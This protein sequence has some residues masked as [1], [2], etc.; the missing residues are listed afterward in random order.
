MMKKRTAVILAL[1]L[2]VSLL[3]GCGSGGNSQQPAATPPASGGT[4]PATTPAAPGQ[5]TAAG[6]D[7]MVCIASDPETIDPAR[8]SSVDGATILQNA[9][10]GLY[11]WSFDASGRQIVVADCAEAVVD[12]VEMAGGKYQYVV[13]LKPGLKWSDGAELKASDFV[14]AWN[15]AVDPA[16]LADY[17]YIFDVIDGYDPENPNLN[18][19]A[20]DDARTV[21]IVTSAYCVYFNQLLAFP[22]YFPVRRDI[23]EADPDAWATKVNSYISNGAFKMTEWVVGSYIRF[24][25]NGNYWNAGEMKLDSLTFALSDDNDAMFANFENGTYQFMRNIPVAQIPIL[26]ETRLNRDFFIGDYIGT[27]YL[28]FNVEYSFKPGLTSAGKSAADWAGWTPEQNAQVRRALG[29]LIDRNFIIEEVTQAGELPADGFVPNGMDDGTGTE[30]RS[31]AESWW[32]TGVADYDANCEEAVN[33]LRQW[34]DYDEATGKFGNFPVFE[35]SINPT[36]RNLAICAA[37]QDIWNDYGIST[38]VD[39]RT[40]A[41]ITT[42]LTEGDFTMSRLGWIADYNDPITFLEIFVRSSGNN[43]PRLGKE[44][45]VG[46]GAYYG[47]GKNQTW[48]DA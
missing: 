6:S 16:T 23:V 39:Q 30:F 10:S 18:I 45:P 1:L 29:L 19:S 41:V 15:R 33:I 21:T 3:A 37:V 28:E 31:R 44:G 8:N 25:P 40:W 24:E 11:A 35:Y 2:F 46:S 14:Y 48:N 17:Q 36:S 32:K 9:F 7:I 38:T 43:H 27:Y 20:D 12:P 5:L 34:Y 42:A 26:K 13:T 47:A 4:P 22:T